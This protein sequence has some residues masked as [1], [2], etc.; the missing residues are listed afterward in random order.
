MLKLWSCLQFTYNF[1]ICL[2]VNFREANLIVRVFINPQNRFAILN[3]MIFLSELNLIIFQAEFLLQS[4]IMFFPVGNIIFFLFRVII[5][6]NDLYYFHRIVPHLLNFSFSWLLCASAFFF[7][8]CNHKIRKLKLIF[9][10]II[11]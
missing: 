7:F 10:E 4:F 6:Q 1:F 11:V 3:F 9:F 8:I 5:M 2:T